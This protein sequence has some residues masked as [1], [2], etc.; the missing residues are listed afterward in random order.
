MSVADDP[1]AGRPSSELDEMV[2]RFEAAWRAGPRPNIDDFLLC[3]E[4]LR[5]PALAELA[6]VEL[7]L[8]LLVGEAARVEEYL[9]RFPELAD[10]P[11]AVVALLKAEYDQRRWREPSLSPEEYWR[12][13]PQ[14]EEQ[15][16][17][18]IGDIPDLLPP[19]H[20]A[21]VATGPDAVRD[22]EMPAQLGR[23][24]ITARLGQGGFGVVYKG[25]DD[26]LRRDVAIKVPHRERVRQAADAEVYLAEAR[27][28]AGLDHPH[29]VPVHDLGRTEDGL[30]FVVSKFI[31]GSNLAERIEQAR[32]SSNEAVHIVAA[33]AEALHYAHTRGLVHRDVKPGN[34]LLD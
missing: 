5:F 12:R 20:D 23:Y 9:L 30:C 29:I 14:Y 33:V 16:R 4:P 25:Y 26:D 22:P 3:G 31:A 11:I 1:V 7:K 15:I 19:R 8:R 21:A 24:R 10:N 18:E 32:P 27:V 34:I 28:V 6:C 17:S 13:F 2:R